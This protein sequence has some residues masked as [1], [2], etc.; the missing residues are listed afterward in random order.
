[1]TLIRISFGMELM[2]E[3]EGGEPLTVCFGTGLVEGWKVCITGG[4]VAL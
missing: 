1:M 4:Y 2:C 3:E